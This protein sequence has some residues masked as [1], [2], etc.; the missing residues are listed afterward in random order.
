MSAT[1]PPKLPSAASDAP[2]RFSD[3]RGEIA[4][5]DLIDGKYRIDALLGQGGM[6]KVFGAKHEVLGQRV[7]VKVL[8]PEIGSLAHAE[9]VVRE[10]QAAAQLTSEHVTRVL[11]IGDLD[12]GEPFLVMERLE[13]ADFGQILQS[14]GPMTVQTVADYLTQACDVIAEAHARGIVHRDL[15]RAIC[16]LRGVVMVHHSSS[17]WT[18]VSRSS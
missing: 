9:R 17:S 14:S 3:A 1:R 6:A 15:K 16:F 5:G 13:G 10:A 8:L 18:S 12:T 2:A 4:I 7:A 11:D